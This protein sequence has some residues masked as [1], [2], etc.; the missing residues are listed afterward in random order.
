[1]QLVPVQGLFSHSAVRDEIV[2]DAVLLAGG[3]RQFGDT[4]R[5]EGPSGTGKAVLRRMNGLP[6]SLRGE[7]PYI[8]PDLGGV[9]QASRTR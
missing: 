5:Q 6:R 7:V 3:I 2:S 8:K 1:M 4:R 9:G